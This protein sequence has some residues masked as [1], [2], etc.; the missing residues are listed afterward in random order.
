MIEPTPNDAA[1]AE[2]MPMEPMAPAGLV[3]SP[4]EVSKWKTRIK[5]AEEHS[6]KWEKWRKAVVKAY[7]PDVDDTP[8]D[9]IENIRTNRLFA[10]IERKKPDLFY[11]RADV[12]IKQSPLL[13][14]IPQGADVATAHEQI[15]NEKLGLDGVK[16]RRKMSR[17]V[18]DM[19]M[20]GVGWVLVGYRA[21]TKDVT[22][23]IPM[24]DE[25][26]QP[27]TTLAIGPDGMPMMQP[28]MTTETVPVPLKTECILENVSP[29][30]V[31]K[32]HT[33]KSMEFDECPWLGWK[34][35]MPLN[36][37]KRMPN[38]TIPDDFKPADAHESRYTVKGDHDEASEENVTG[39]ILSLKSSVFREDI[40]HPDHMTELVFIDGIPEPVCYQDSPHQTFT[41]DGKLTP[42]SLEG[43]P[44][45][46]VYTRV[47]TDS[48][49]VMSDAAMLMPLNNELDKFRQQAIV[50]RNIN[51]LRWLASDEVP[52][53]VLD[54][55]VYSGIGG[56]IRVPKD[57]LQQFDLN[58][59]QFPL[60]AMP[61]DN[62]AAAS[63]MDGDIS[64]TISIDA[65]AQGV[66]N[67]GGTTATESNIVQA[68]RNV[69]I[70]S[71]QNIVAEHYISIVTKLS[72]L[73]QR[74][75]TPED[76]AVIVGQ[77]KA[78]MWKQWATSLPTRLSFTVLPD[79]Q[80]R[81]DTP[82]DRKQDMDLY[83]FFRNDPRVRPVPLLTDI[84]QKA[85]KDTRKLI[86]PDNEMQK[87]GPDPTKL[88]SAMKGED[89]SPLSPQFP[90]MAELFSSLTGVPISP[91]ALQNAMALAKLAQ[92]QK[93]QEEAAKQ[94]GGEPKHGGPVKQAE[95]MSKH[96]S[97]QT[98]G[99]E[100]NGAM[101]DGMGGNANAPA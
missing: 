75:L 37:A 51:V 89:F 71:E 42:D 43:H 32:P 55:I 23:E 80:L 40:I 57:I 82:L 63:T 93:A 48:S 30:Q 101:L 76:A 20:F 36:H 38:W 26:G 9:Y 54:N 15:I 94:P 72:T 65:N 86:V 85:H 12:S 27:V 31:L 50:M 79:S 17:A 14:A 1:G 74:Y 67:S 62:W 92:A 3:L 78:T 90:I 64:R 56:V 4:D 22:R 41:P 98:G 18:F 81:N 6:K 58:F 33:W 88:L 73:V 84:L 21:Y 83:Q 28:L 99:N 66:V 11:Q 5:R 8:D 69:S 60:G 68:N 59:R 52:E 47:M 44:L 29:S 10:A 39:V 61:P 53:K 45:N 77:Q 25:M 24:L 13:D 97:D 7:A 16:A 2:P 19:L 96:H 49:D 87:P 91:Q 46:A 34:F 35:E 100:G 95:P 70:G